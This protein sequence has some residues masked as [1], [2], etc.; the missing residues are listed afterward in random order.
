MSIAFACYL[1][2][3]VYC[4]YTCLI[5]KKVTGAAKLIWCLAIFFLPLVGGILW[6]LINRPWQEES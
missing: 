2:F 1:A 5:S 3:V 4:A 6:L